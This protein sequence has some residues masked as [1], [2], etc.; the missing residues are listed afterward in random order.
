MNLAEI[1]EKK[2]VEMG[3]WV[4]IITAQPHCIYYFGPFESTKE[5]ALAQDGYLE[6]LVNEG[7][8]GITVEIKWCKPRDLTIF[9]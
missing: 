1:G 7:T 9:P 4:E 3:W 8:Q 5:A 6:D 2:Q